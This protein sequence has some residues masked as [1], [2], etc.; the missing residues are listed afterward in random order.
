[1]SVTD[2]RLERLAAKLGRALHARRWR[3]ATAESCTGGW[4]A[5]AATDVGGA[6]RWFE[7]GVV[8]YSNTAKTNLL[9]VPRRLL[10]RG[11][12]GAVSQA[13]VRA[14]A[15]GARAGFG[16]DVAVAVSGVAGPDGGTAKKPVGTVWFAWATA[17]GTLAERHVFPGNRAAVRRATVALA[18][19][20]L[21][22]LAAADD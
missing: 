19:E 2:R 15:E 16:V 3:L 4:I 1:V 13:T 18:F 21:I 8:T 14:M 7:G 9:A 6:S 22:E 17:G 12:P 11:G 20:R 10:S 5:K